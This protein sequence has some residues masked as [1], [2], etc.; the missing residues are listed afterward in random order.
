VEPLTEFQISEYQIVL[1]TVVGMIAVAY[2][3]VLAVAN[4]EVIPDS[5]LYSKFISTRT[6]M[7]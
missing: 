7:S 3:A 6:K 4:M 2:S 1:W 5:I